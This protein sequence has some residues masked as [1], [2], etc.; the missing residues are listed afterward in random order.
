VL[1]ECLRIT[2]ARLQ[3]RRRGAGK[4]ISEQP[5][6]PGSRY[7]LAAVRH[8]VWRR[9]GGQCTFVGSTGQRCTSRHQLELHHIAPFAR[10]GPP[11][12]ANLTLRC[13]AHNRYAAEKDFG[14]EHIA[15]QIAARHG[16][17]EPTRG[18]ELPSL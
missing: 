3:G 1:H 8:E 11:T 16:P 13:R 12:T 10:G 6:R 2:L 17:R 9:D 7:V 18:P 15:R 5:P 14:S 4:K